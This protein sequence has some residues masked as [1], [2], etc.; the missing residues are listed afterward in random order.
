V[1]DDRQLAIARQL[2]RQAD[3]CAESGESLY[4]GLLRH[5]AEDAARGGPVWNLLQAHAAEPAAAALPLRFLAGV[6]R[7]V[8]SGRAPELADAYAA[9]D[10][11]QAWPRFRA[12]VEEH[13][14]Y[15]IEQV[16]RPCQTNEVGRSAALLGGFL[17][18]AQAWRRPLRLLEVG[19][20]AGLNLRWDHYRYQAGGLAWGDPASPV[21]LDRAY[22]VPPP[23]EPERVRIAER[24]GCDLQP[25]DPTSPEGELALAA[26][27]WPS[28]PQRLHLLKAAIQVAH[29]VP[30]VVDQAD[31]ATWLETKLS[32]PARSV[33]TVVFHS[34]FVQYLAPASRA[35][36]L[37]ALARAGQAAGL[38]APLAWLRME[39]GTGAFEV[40]LTTWPGGEERLLGTCGPHGTAVRWL[41]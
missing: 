29:R 24:A 22:V 36:I 14:E 16:A 37:R 2:R 39:P 23:F 25:I 7:L 20:S 33:V 17:E 40:R 10:P 12:L 31:A 9:A 13:R 15:L 35:R 1:P 19:T 27:V 38:D 11:E 26:F 34:V 30:A 8:L 41:R 4:A 32:T 21:C 28:N 3:W 18:L 5:S 6:N